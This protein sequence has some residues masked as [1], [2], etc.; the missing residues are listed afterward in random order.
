MIKVYLI[1]DSKFEEVLNCRAIVKSLLLNFFNICLMLGGH[2]HMPLTLVIMFKV[3]QSVAHYLILEKDLFGI[4]FV[5]N[6]S[7]ESTSLFKGTSS[8]PMI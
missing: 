4:M 3:G 8:S 6:N 1:I 2:H 5:V 7:P